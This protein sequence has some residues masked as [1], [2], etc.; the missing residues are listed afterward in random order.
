[1]NLFPRPT[2]LILAAVLL[3][4]S[5]S[6]AAYDRSSIEFFRSPQSAF[7]S[8]QA[9]ENDLVSKRIRAES[10]FSFLVEYQN[11]S[12][13]VNGI[14]IARDLSLSTK[15]T[16]VFTHL[17]YK[18]IEQK[19]ASVYAEEESSG[20]RQWLGL[21][22]L[23]TV[24]TDLGLAINLISTPLREQPTWKSDT[25]ITIPAQSQVEIIKFV[26]D[27]IMVKFNSGSS[28]IGYLPNQNL[29]TKF[30]FAHHIMTADKEW[31][32]VKYREHC[33]MVTSKNKRIHL[34]EVIAVQTTPDIG[35]SLVQDDSKMLVYKAHLKIK[36]TLQESWNVSSF[37]GHG[38]VYWK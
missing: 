16:D 15:I 38:E 12:Y 22:N 32:E 30:D 11:K 24:S 1:M 29:I 23:T 6:Y 25:S 20:K 26:D 33:S 18:I 35:I 19:G 13:W 3:F 2:P 14:D 5:I 10:I 21:Q 4:S 36:K 34:S 28:V 7:R 31:I 9:T 37:K 8:G 17:T 27:W